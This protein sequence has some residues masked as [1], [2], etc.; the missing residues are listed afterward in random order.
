[1]E[2]LFLLEKVYRDP[3]ALSRFSQFRC[4]SINKGEIIQNLNENQEF[5]LCFVL[6]G[7]LCFYKD[8]TESI[9]QL[10]TRNELFFVSRF[11]KCNIR[12]VD[13]VQIIVHACNI[14]APY[15]HSRI[16]EYLG[17]VTVDK[18][19]PLEVLPIYPL[20]TS[21]L[22]L[23]VEYMKLKAE[24]PD[25]HLAKEYELF[26]L[27]KICY[28]K[29]QI[30]SI[31]R[32]AL[33]KDLQFFVTVMRHYKVCRTA[34][35]LAEACGYS[36]NIFTQLF[37]DCFQGCTPYQWLQRQTSGEIEYK[38]KET[39]QPIK[40]IM[41]EYHFKTFSHFTTYCKRNIGCTPNEIRRK[42]MALQ[43]P[44]PVTVYATSQIDGHVNI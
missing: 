16:L 38:L 6:K 10:V 13:D 29:N 27:F 11:H 24:I 42:E 19:K 33:S 34:K 8:Q 20:M 23:L 32:D 44:S 43:C 18:V 41:L 26:S 37:K 7:T 21:Y 12:A 25:L 17:D 4:L 9:P 15:F 28:S 39:K 1:M 5:Q 31:F 3:Y 2:M 40:E 30:V 22:D 35:E 36:T 14:V